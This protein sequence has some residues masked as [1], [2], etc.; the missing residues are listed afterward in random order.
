MLLKGIKEIAEQ[1]EKRND[2]FNNISKIECSTWK[3]EKISFS[4]HFQTEKDLEEVKEFIKDVYFGRL[5]FLNCGKVF[6]TKI[7]ETDDFESI[8][9]DTDE[10]SHIHLYFSYEM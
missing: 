10:V 7:E 3:E 9:V 8:E 4:I 5:T 6:K 2:L 1:L